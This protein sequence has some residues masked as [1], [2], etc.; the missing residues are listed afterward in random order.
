MARKKAKRGRKFIGITFE[1]CRVY[2]RIYLNEAGTAYEGCCP[3]CMRPV[4]V[5]VDKRGT[6]ARFFKAY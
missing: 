6:D 4:E 2:Q 1:C 3:K 5:K